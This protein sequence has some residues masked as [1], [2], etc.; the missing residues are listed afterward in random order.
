MKIGIMGLAGAGK[1][2]FAE[3]L[4]KHLPGARIDRFASPLKKAAEYVFG[5]YFDD[6]VVKEKRIPVT[7]STYDRMIEGAMQ[8]CNELG[9]TEQEEEAA[10]LYFFESA[11]GE[12]DPDLYLSCEDLPRISPREYQQLLGTEVIRKVRETAFSDRIKNMQGMV[13]LTDCRFSTEVQAV[14]YVLLVVRES[15]YG[16]RPEH[17]SE[18]LS[19]DLT[20]LF[21]SGDWNSFPHTL[22]VIRNE[23]TKYDLDKEALYTSKRIIRILNTIN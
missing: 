4:L 8:V 21:Y 3:E 9:F 13:L 6:R 19:W 2:T 17:S 18:H 14:D 1:D 23:G 12:K 16:A 10:S 11:L 5:P 7:A 22:Q 15:V 20:D